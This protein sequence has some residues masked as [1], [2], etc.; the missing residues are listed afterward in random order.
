[1][2]RLR[3]GAKIRSVRKERNRGS[4]IKVMLR[5]LGNRRKQKVMCLEYMSSAMIIS[6]PYH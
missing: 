2:K 5:L 1:M 4:R 3:K 6:V